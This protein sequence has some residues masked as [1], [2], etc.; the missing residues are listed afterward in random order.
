MTTGGEGGMVTTDDEELWSRDVVVQG[1][2]QELGGGLRAPAPAGLRWLHESFGT[3]WRMPEMQAA[4]GR[5]QLKRMADWTLR[6]NQNAQVLSR[7]LA[8]IVA[9]ARFAGSVLDR[10][11]VHRLLQVLRLCDAPTARRAGWNRDRI[12]AGNHRAG[13]AVLSWQLLGGLSRK[14]V[15]R[16]RLGARPNGCRSRAS[17]ARPA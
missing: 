16:H 12:V 6:R 11:R 8:A 1:P 10:G 14:G 2:R 17:S 7:A 3:N 5:I 4:I 13:H 9:S 15:R